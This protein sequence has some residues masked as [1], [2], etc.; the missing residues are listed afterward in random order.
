MTDNQTWRGDD[1]ASGHPHPND[2][3]VSPLMNK[4]GQ[5]GSDSST[6]IYQKTFGED[7]VH[8]DVTIFFIISQP[9]LDNSILQQKE[10][11]AYWTSF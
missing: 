1:Q 10:V 6:V 4:Y 5:T 11:I 9:Y 2:Q 8:Y 7:V 3:M